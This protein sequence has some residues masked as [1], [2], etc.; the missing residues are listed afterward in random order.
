MLGNAELRWRDSDAVRT[1]RTDP[2]VTPAC[3]QPKREVAS[4]EWSGLDRTWFDRFRNLRHRRLGQQQYAGNRYRVLERNPHD[5]RRIDDSGL[6]QVDVT[7][8]RCVE[9]H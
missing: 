1:A 8:G 2:N 7:V 6:D 4:T 5:F 3:K 9:A